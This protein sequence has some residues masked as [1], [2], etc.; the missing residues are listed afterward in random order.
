MQGSKIWI[1]PY[2]FILLINVICVKISRIPSGMA[3]LVGQGGACTPYQSLLRT[4]CRKLIVIL[5]DIESWLYSYLPTLLNFKN[6][7]RDGI[8]PNKIQ[9]N[10][11]Q[12]EV[13]NL[14]TSLNQ[15]DVY[16][17]SVPN[18]KTKHN[19]YYIFIIFQIIWS[20]SM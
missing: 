1:W 18:L 6:W 8:N 17:T 5:L 13:K 7:A 4:N 3:P 2:V 20:L 16:F 14:S 19:L 10:F 11:I 15:F 9:S 12:W